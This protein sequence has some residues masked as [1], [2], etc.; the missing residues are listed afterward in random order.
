M[1]QSPSAGSPPSTAE[2]RSGA[3]LADANLKGLDMAGKSL[4]GANLRG[5]DLAGANLRVCNL[6]GCD[7]SGADFLWRLSGRGFNHRSRAG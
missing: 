6:N 2:L 4:A 3:W 7:L 5:A 1:I